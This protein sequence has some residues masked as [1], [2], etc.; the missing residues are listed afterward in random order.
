MNFL[1]ENLKI[2]KKIFIPLFGLILFTNTLEQY[3]SLKV[4][5]AL[6]DPSG[7]QAKIF[8]LGF[9][10][11][12]SSIVFPVLTISIVLFAFNSFRNSI[13]AL[14]LFFK[15]NLNLLY[16]ETLRAWGKT[17]L[18]S[19]LFIIPGLWKFIEY[20]FV[21]FVVTSS[22][23]YDE[24]KIDALKK[25]ATI[26]RHNWIK[27]LAIFIFFHIF[28]PLILSTLFDAYRLI[29]KTPVQSLMLTVLDTYLFLISTHI[30]FNIFR[31]EVKEHEAH[32]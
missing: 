15:K 10:S 24:G 9:L 21:P 11:I 5:S 27:V 23:K 25:S 6:Q 22:K 2:F 1:S 14:H 8:F 18:W 19:L 13:E 29:W 28:I 16:I 17:L 30:L 12:V 20:S 26:V 3:L 7:P 31:N 4:E 32:V